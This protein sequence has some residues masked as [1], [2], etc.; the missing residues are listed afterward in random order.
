MWLNWLAFFEKLKMPNLPVHLFAEDHV[1][2]LRCK[3]QLSMYDEDYHNGLD[4][5]CLSWDTVFPEQEVKIRIGGMGYRTSQYKKM[6]SRRPAI[7]QYELEM[8]HNVIFSDVDTVWKKNPLPYFDDFST[9]HILVE[10]DGER[11]D[12][13]NL[14]PGFM[15]YRSCPETIAFVA[16]WGSKIEGEEKRNQGAF[17][18]LVWKAA[19]YDLEIVVE[20]LPHELFP[21]GGLYFDT[22]T[23]SERSKAVVIHNNGISGYGHKVDRMKAFDLWVS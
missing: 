22:M 6:M 18:K 16:K 1:T 2:Y 17:N 11:K 20:T 9:A 8:G 21:S 7:I 3:D 5:V 13:A 15:V 19:K 4:L 10:W 12:G 23:D 14:C